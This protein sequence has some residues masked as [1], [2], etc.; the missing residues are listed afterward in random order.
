MSHHKNCVRKRNEYK[1]RWCAVINKEC[2]L[3][4]FHFQKKKWFDFIWNWKRTKIVIVKKQV[5]IYELL[6]LYAH[7]NFFSLVVRVCCILFFL[8]SLTYKKCKYHDQ[9]MKKNI[10]NGRGLQSCAVRAWVFAP[11]SRHFFWFC[12]FSPVVDIVVL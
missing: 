7:L 3:P 12:R 4:S 1:S 9:Q 10:R 11:P 2:D 6:L 5:T 8:F